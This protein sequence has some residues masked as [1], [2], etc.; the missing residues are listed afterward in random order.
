MKINKFCYPFA[1]LLSLSA[2]AQSPLAQSPPPGA[3]L[4]KQ[5]FAG[6]T[7][8]IRTEMGEWWKDSTIA[9][10]LQ[11]SDGQITQLD[12]TFY[13]HKMKLVDYGAE[14]EKEDMKLQK[15]L[16]ADVPDEGQVGTQVDQVLTARGKLER[17]YTMMNLDLRK[18]LT[19]EQWRQLKSIREERGG[20]G[21]RF[22]F[23]KQVPPGGPHPG[24]G[25]ELLPPPPLPPPPLDD[26]F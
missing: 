5:V 18:V 23:H 7:V 24:P 16:D 1:F 3:T 9:K 17:E 25:A 14:M 8:K 15:I 2:L 20:P 12:Q 10:K 13:D 22:F 11:L 21:D 26:S 6:P 19:I 4:H